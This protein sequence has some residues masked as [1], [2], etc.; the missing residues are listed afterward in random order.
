MFGFEKRK[1][2]LRSVEDYMRTQEVLSA[3]PEESKPPRKRA[4]LGKLK[5]LM[6]P[7]IGILLILV[8]VAAA[9]SQFNSLRSEIAALKAAQK[10][11]DVK[12]LTAR[13]AD[14][15]AR[16]ERSEKRAA[17]LTQEISGLE[18]A[19]ETERS[20]RIR[21]VAAVSRPAHVVKKAAAKPAASGA[22]RRVS[23]SRS[24]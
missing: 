4:D 9:L 2:Q 11:D 13:V 15:T 5:P 24:R 23:H 20:E 3:S 8:F 12:E 6:G 7:A 17:A 18:K 19:L 22:S 16:L 21:S 1:I 14:M 10:G